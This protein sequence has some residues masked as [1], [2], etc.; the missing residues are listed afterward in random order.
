MNDAPRM[1]GTVL[2]RGRPTNG[3]YVW[4]QAVRTPLLGL[5]AGEIGPLVRQ[6]MVLHGAQQQVFAARLAAH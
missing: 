3:E 2:L 4:H 6:Q 1:Y 5:F